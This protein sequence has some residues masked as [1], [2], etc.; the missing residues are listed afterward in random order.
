MRII[1]VVV[2][3]FLA[4]AA[5]IWFWPT[6]ES[7]LTEVGQPISPPLDVYDPVSA[8]E[9]TPPGYRQIFARDAIEPVY[10]PRFVPADESDWIEGTLVIGVE[11]DGEAKAYPVNFLNWREMVNDWIGETPV[12]VTW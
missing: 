8:G 2:I 4:F 6:D 1:S 12:L 9:P 10:D 3:G 11:I 5:A 7:Q